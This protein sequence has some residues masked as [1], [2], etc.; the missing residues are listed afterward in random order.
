MARPWPASPPA[1]R[2]VVFTSVCG[3]TSV[4][5]GTLKWRMRGLFAAAISSFAFF[6]PATVI[7]MFDCPEQNQTSPTSTSFS[8]TV[9]LPFT[10]NFAPVL[11]AFSAGSATVHLPPAAVVSAFC[12]PNST[13]TFSPSSAQPQTGTF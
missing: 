5:C 13:V 7:S 6:E 3:V 4:T 11:F 10:V 9:F 2:P 1:S 8:S 12:P